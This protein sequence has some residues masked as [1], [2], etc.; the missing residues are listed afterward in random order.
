MGRIHAWIGEGAIVLLPDGQLVSRRAGEF[1]PTERKFEPLTKEALS[2]RLEGEFPG[3]K[4]KTTNHYVFVYN[5]SE[6]FEFGTSRIL[7]TMLPGVKAY[8]EQ[9]KLAVHNPP[10][11]LVAV[12]FHTE[13][14]FQKH[15]RMP[16]GVVAYYDGLTYV[17]VAQRLAANL[18]TVKSRMRDALRGLRNCLDVP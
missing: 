6:V 16:D 13:E 8:A 1:A 7:E 15:R 18:S 3:F 11:P 2:T 12:M 4:T 14:E 5:T 17:E 9:C 10:V